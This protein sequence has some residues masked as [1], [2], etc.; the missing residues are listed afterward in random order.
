MRCTPCTAKRMIGGNWW[1]SKLLLLLLVLV[2]GCRAHSCGRIFQISGHRWCESFFSSFFSRADVFLFVVF[3]YSKSFDVHCKKFCVHSSD[4]RS[5]LSSIFVFEPRPYHV[6]R[7]VNAWTPR[8]FLLA[9]EFI[10]IFFPIATLL[11]IRLSL[12]PFLVSLLR[13]SFRDPGRLF[14]EDRIHWD[15]TVRDGVLAIYGRSKYPVFVGNKY[16]FISSLD[17]S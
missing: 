17:A 11:S 3:R 12:P 9:Q 10:Q 8:G 1:T 7:K 2:Q 16:I 5:L 6:G 4:L 13:L 15:H 14:F